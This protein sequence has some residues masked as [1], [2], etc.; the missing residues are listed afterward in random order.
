[1]RHL[2]RSAQTHVAPSV[3]A[4]QVAPLDVHWP[5]GED[6]GPISTAQIE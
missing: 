2:N 3:F 5:S 6:C 4:L 1:V